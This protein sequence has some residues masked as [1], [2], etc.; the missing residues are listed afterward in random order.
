MPLEG[1]QLGR[2][3]LL[4]VLG[5]G[6]MGEVYLGEDAHIHRQVAIKVVRTE[7]ASYPDT[8]AIRDSE[9]LF[10]REVRAIATL[11]HPHILPLFDYGEETVHNIVYTYMVMPLRSEGSLAQWLRQYNTSHPLSRQQITHI[12]SQHDG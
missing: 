12:I 9:R 10:R 6:G 8:D 3:R 5:S 2:Y 1:L 4:S 7:P 11:D